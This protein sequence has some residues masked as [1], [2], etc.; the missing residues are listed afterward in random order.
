MRY[1]S[2]NGGKCVHGIDRNRYG[3]ATEYDV[4]RV[5]DFGDWDRAEDVFVGNGI[6]TAVIRGG[7]FVLQ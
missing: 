2:G 7:F 1:C 6:G 5:G 3:F 4:L